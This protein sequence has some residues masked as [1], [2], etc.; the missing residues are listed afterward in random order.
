MSL[1]GKLGLARAAGRLA[2]RTDASAAGQARAHLVLG[3]VESQRVP[4]CP[5][6][7][8]PRGA[9]PLSLGKAQRKEG[10][11]V[12]LLCNLFSA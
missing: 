1:G 3:E 10:G 4:C 6:S 2:P 8:E 5:I 11:L 12:P 9:V 7:Q